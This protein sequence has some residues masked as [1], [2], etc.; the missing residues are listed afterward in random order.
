VNEKTEI[1]VTQPSARRSEYE[2]RA[3]ERTVGTL[4]WRRGRRS[5]AQAEGVGVGSL[6]LTAK[7][8][9]I[10]VS[11]KGAA[12]GRFATLERE[13]HGWAIHLAQ[14]PAFHWNQVRPDRWAV[15]RDNTVV[16]EFAASQGLVTSSLLISVERAE[17]ED[18]VVL[19]CLIGAFLALRALRTAVDASAAVGGIVAT[20]AG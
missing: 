8:R 9:H 11:G 6:E 17:R 19:L 4:R 5:V 18:M 20:G 3:G 15:S 2:I 7:R 1:R 16:M 14:G 13:G 12:G 10:F